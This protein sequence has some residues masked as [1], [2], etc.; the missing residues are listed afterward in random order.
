MLGK[1]LLLFIG[2]PL[3]ELALLLWIGQRVGLVPTVALVVATGVAGAA[4]ARSQGL[5][6]LGRIRAELAAG[7][8]PAQELLDGALVLVAGATLLTPGLL[9]DVF[10]LLLLLPGTRGWVRA[11]LGARMRRW[12]ERG[13]ARMIIVRPEESPPVERPPEA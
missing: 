11:R 10:G 12:V 3:L 8:M 2:V 6:V 9:T 1:L 7:S 13:Q 5:R 4:L